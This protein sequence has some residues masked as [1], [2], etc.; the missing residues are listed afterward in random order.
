MAVFARQLDADTSNS[1]H[2]PPA[3]QTYTRSVHHYVVPEVP[4]VAMDGS[5]TALADA[6]N[7][8]GPVLVNFIFTT[9]NTICPVLT[10]TFSQAQ[11][12]LAV[13]APGLRFVSISIDPE[14][15]TPSKLREYANRFNAGPDWQFLT[16]EVEQIIA[17]QQAFD[18]YRGDKMNHASLTLM[19]ISTTSPWVR[20]EGQAGAQDLINEYRL[21]SAGE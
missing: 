19:R 7:D 8:G 2:A 13:E 20:I 1:L 21:S 4:L 15:D 9:C 6:L 5:R 10:A 18:A 3:R 11:K 14:Y 16:G 12:S 17:V